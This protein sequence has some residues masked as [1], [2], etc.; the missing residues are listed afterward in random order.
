MDNERLEKMRLSNTLRKSVLLT[1]RETG[2]TQ[3]FSSKTDAGIYLG[4]SR[5]SVSKC[6]L[7]NMPYKGYTISKAPSKDNDV[8]ELSSTFS[9]IKQQPVR[10]TNKLTGI[11][12]EF[13]S[14]VDAAKFLDIS[15]ARLWYFLS[16]LSN[17]E[18]DTLKGYT[19]FKIMDTQVKVN[20]KSVSIEVTDIYTKE[21]KIYPSL[22]LAAEALDV[23]RSCLSGYFAKKRTKP[24][25]NKYNLKLV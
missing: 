12:K 22:T 10:L 13:S 7:N 19:I 23:A 24:Y 25:K 6:L 5:V 20:R 3:V 21:V 16:N 17:I 1:N 15:R 2:K 4:I 8:A 18:N 14:M 11:S 9:F